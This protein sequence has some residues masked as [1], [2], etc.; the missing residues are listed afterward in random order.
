M[1]D[2]SA[3]EPSKTCVYLDFLMPRIFLQRFLRSLRC[4]RATPFALPMP[5]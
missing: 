4:L 3:T 5:N 2:M 1:K